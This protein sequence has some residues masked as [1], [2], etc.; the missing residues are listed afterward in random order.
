MSADDD[1]L[2]GET[3]SGVRAGLRAPEPWARLAIVYPRGVEARHEIRGKAPVQFGR[4]P[5]EETGRRVVHRTV[6]RAHL[7][8]RWD[9]PARSY[10]ARDLGSRN[11]SWI[12]GVK[13]DER[14]IPL[15]DGTVVR[16]GDVLGTFEVIV[17]ALADGD[18]VDRAAVPGDATLI[19]QLRASIS[20][21][22]PDPSPVLV[23]GETGVGK[24]LIAA[25]IHRLSGRKAPMLSLNCAELSPTVIESQLFGHEKGAFTGAA[26]AAQGLFRAAS[27][28]T[29]FLDEIGELPLDLQ[30]KLLRV[31]QTGEVL[32]V[33]GTKKTKVD[34][35]IV[36]ATNRVL[37]NEVNEGRFRRDLY[38]RLSLNELH[39]PPVRRRRS[40]IMSWID[41]LHR[42]WLSARGREQ[43]PFEFQPDAAEVLV[44]HA[45]A[46]NLRG[47]DRLVH[48]LAQA[49]S[50][51]P[52][53]TASLPQWLAVDATSTGEPA[54][55]TA[56][57]TASA[58]APPKRQPIPKKEELLAV[59]NEHNWVIRAVATHFGRDRR[60]VYRWM[61]NYGIKRDGD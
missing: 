55:S 58:P 56:P 60:Q 33:G 28:G 38:A 9:G 51:D 27:G 19:G 13:A 2:L 22:A 52:I 48:T 59:L 20:R 3:I 43:P 10:V 17:G 34:V 45:W 40:D 53:G 29:L 36:A 21:A 41:V 23:I 18:D 12:D 39:V 11:G 5:A 24:E 49:E 26:G 54:T 8:I 42:A 6:S 25:E 57:A 14:P 35:R 1:E 15:R 32:A 50:T 4:N 16:I 61:D 30:P 46:E 31:I 44:R 47:I 7:E 37:A